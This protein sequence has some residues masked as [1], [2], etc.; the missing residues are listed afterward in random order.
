MGRR[1]GISWTTLPLQADT[2]LIV[3]VMQMDNYLKQVEN[4]KEAEKQLMSF[5]IQNITDEIFRNYD[6]GIVHCLND[7]EFVLLFNEKSQ[8]EDKHIQISEEIIHSLHKY[9]K[10]SVSIGMGNQVGSI[11]RVYVS[12]KNAVHAVQHKFYMDLRSI[13]RIEDITNICEA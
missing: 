6:A 4:K 3:A 8:H 2:C 11:D 12:Y 10:I 1:S 7:N 5:S 13:I 9:L